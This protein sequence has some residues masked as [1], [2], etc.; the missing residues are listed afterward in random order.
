MILL[1]LDTGCRITEALSVRVSDVDFETCLS[2]LTAR[3]E[4]SGLS[5]SGSLFERLCT[6]TSADF[7]RK[8]DSLLFAI[9]RVRRSAE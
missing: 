7:N 9:R 8:P 3:G 6:V 1:L 2:R 5:L 4:S